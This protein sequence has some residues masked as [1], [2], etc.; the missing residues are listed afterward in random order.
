[1][2]VSSRHRAA[3]AFL[4]A[5]FSLGAAFAA[6]G[7]G[8]G[9]LS[10]SGQWRFHPGDLSSAEL[11]ELQRGALSAE[12]DSW[13]NIHAPSAWPAQGVKR[14]R[15]G[16]YL[17]RLTLPPHLMGSTAELGLRIG[18]AWTDVRVFANGRALE[19][20]TPRRS[21]EYD[22]HFLL[23]LP[24]SA[25][26][27]DGTTTLCIRVAR[28]P[29]ALDNEGGLTAEPLELGLLADLAA[30]SA[31]GDIPRLL[32]SVLFL[33]VCVAHLLLYRTRRGSVEYFW[34][35][36]A[37]LLMAGHTF[38]RTQ[39]RFVFGEHFI[40]YKELEYACI[41]VLT[42]VLVEF[43]AVFLAL[44]RPWWLRAYQA[45]H[46]LLLLTVA[47]TP[48]L[49]INWVVLPF[50][51]AWVLPVLI[52]IPVRVIQ[53][54][55]RGRREAGLIL[56]GVVALAVAFGTDVAITQ[57]LIQ[58]PGFV[59]GYGF[60]L[61]AI[62]LGA[63]MAD[64]F[65][66][67]QSQVDSLNQ[68]LE[69]QVRVRTLQL[70]D[71]RFA[72]EAANRAKT[73]FLGNMSHE[74]RTPLNGV[75]GMNEILLLTPLKPDQR[76][77]AEAVRDS[78]RALLGLVEDVL[79]LSRVESGAL[80]IQLEPTDVRAACETSIDFFRA[81]ASARST[82]VSLQVDPAFPPLLLTDPARL[83]QILLNLIGNAIK[84][85]TQGEVILGAAWTEPD[86]LTLFVRDT[87]MGIPP[88]L[89]PR[90]FLPFTQGD[91]SLTRRHG[92]AGLGLSITRH[93]VILMGGSIDVES[94][95]GEGATFTVRL[96][97]P[98]A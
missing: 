84:F 51:N 71:A 62:F 93:I 68:N 69:A 76:E 4:V 6:T 70:E 86:A 72:A 30:R 89:L 49:A 96:P 19:S 22:R 67:L 43:F 61:F 82:R 25:I 73:A 32:L 63:A 97:A 55:R 40:L 74:M 38:L 58:G 91:D 52:G 95:P 14:T 41:Y 42:P 81:G 36:L 35:S 20:V 26:Q 37:A 64:R 87:G 54:F 46:L 83:R 48:G 60:G 23:A 57:R 65:G 21:F 9:P 45:S 7:E 78:G 33:Y 56:A 10:L 2:I 1:M 24:R 94:Q 13:I 18:E 34:F 53:A 17:R 98:R 16:W 31:T 59:G 47:L 75:I 8:E 50:W 15:V 28:D 88:E 44:P 79:D 3:A 12:G 39:F 66:H 85:T 29:D 92:G 11:V 90:L 77:Y 5:W 27:P 80:K